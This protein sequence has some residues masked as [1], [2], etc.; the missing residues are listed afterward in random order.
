MFGNELILRKSVF[1]GKVISQNIGTM[2]YTRPKKF[3]KPNVNKTTSQRIQFA[4]RETNFEGVRAKRI[5]NQRK[6]AIHVEAVL[7]GISI[8]SA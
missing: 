6:T 4:M 1:G 3:M 2:A 7:Y 5:L 8:F